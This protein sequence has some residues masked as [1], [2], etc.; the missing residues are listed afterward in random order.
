M[1]PAAGLF[2]ALLLAG[3]AAPIAP[4]P[5]R[6]VAVGAAIQ[7]DAEP[8]PLDPTDPRRDRIGAFVYAGGVALTSRQTSRLHGMSDLKVSADGRL[9]AIGDQAD[10]LEARVVLDAGGR[11]TGLT[12]ATLVSLKAPDGL[13]LF[14]GGQR[15]YD[16]E[17]IAQLPSGDVVVS[18]EQHDRILVFPK[19]GG[20]PRPAP[21][22]DI[23]YVDNQGMEA[24]AS[25]PE[26][27]ADAYRVGL[28]SS[29]HTYIC[30]LSTTCARDRDLPVEGP[31][32]VAFDN[33]PGGGLA[34]LL[35]T[36]TAA[37][38]NVVKLRII[39]RQG[40]LVDALELARPLTVDNLEGLAA[41][42]RPNGAVRFYLIAD[43]NFGYYAGRPTGQRTLLLAFDWRPRREGPR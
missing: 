8:V 27:A 34:Y 1:R 13:D 37:R 33:M 15:E 36:Y 29:G 16:S 6:P 10:M 9:L 39:D 22:P 21:A 5:E 24:L 7:V 38:G 30:R 23:R 3:C 28:E 35:R 17:G 11:L 43:D 25:A 26:V 31:D 20:L 32:L 41:V 18:F 19:G 14:A 12:G 42:P 40:R 2:A 4:L